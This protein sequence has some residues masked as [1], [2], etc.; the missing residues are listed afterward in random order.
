[1]KKYIYL[2]EDTQIF[3]ILRPGL[4]VQRKLRP[5]KQIINYPRKRQT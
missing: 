3:K 5:Y 2:D 4:T 1:M